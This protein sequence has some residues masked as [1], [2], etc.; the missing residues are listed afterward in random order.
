MG[1]VFAFPIPLSFET[2]FWIYV[3]YSGIVGIPA[4]YEAYRYDDMG[5]GLK[6][7]GWGFVLLVLQVVSFIPVFGAIIYFFVVKKL[8]YPEMKKDGLDTRPVKFMVALMVVL[9]III[10][11]Y[12]I[13]MLLF[14]LLFTRMH[15]RSQ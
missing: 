14:I 11:I 12:A 8:I 10:N 1:W 4:I 2:L 15:Q 5:R 9:S 7:L 3:L 6:I 13:L